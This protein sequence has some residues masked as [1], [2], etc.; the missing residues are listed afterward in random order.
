MKL[1]HRSLVAAISAALALSCGGRA[2]S[3]ISIDPASVELSPNGKQKFSV[4][5]QGATRTAV[6]W[7][8]TDSQGSIDSDGNY[9]AGST[10][11]QFKVVATLKT[12]ASVS[13]SATVT[14]KQA[15]AQVTVTPAMAQVRSGDTLRLTATVTGV[16]DDGLDW[17]VAEAD[18]G[19]VDASG[20]YTAPQTL[21]TYT[22]RATSVERK[23][24][25]GE[26][27]LR[28]VEHVG[29][30]VAPTQVVLR[31]GESAKF[32]AISA[33]PA[34]A[35]VRWELVEPGAP[36]NLAQDGTYTAS[37]KGGTL[38][39][40]AVSKQD[41]T[42]LATA[43]L[44]V[45]FPPIT[46]SGT[47]AVTGTPV[48]GPVHIVDYVSSPVTDVSP[49]VIL[50]APGPFTIE[51][52]E[53]LSSSL[54]FYGFVDKFGGSNIDNIG[55]HYVDIQLDGSKTMGL[56]LNYPDDPPLGKPAQPAVID[57]A[58]SSGTTV[59]LTWD[60]YVDQATG[61]E[62]A[63][64]YR[65]YWSHQANPGPQNKEGMLEVPANELFGFYTAFVA[66]LTASQ[67]YNFAVASVVDGAEIAL[68]TPQAIAVGSRSAGDRTL[69][70]TVKLG[71]LPLQGRL[72]VLARSTSFRFADLGTPT[73]A[74]V[75]YTIDNLEAGKT[76]LVIYLWDR[77]G[78]GVFNFGVDR[79]SSSAELA[80]V[81]TDNLPA[82]VDLSVVQTP[83]GVDLKSFSSIDQG[84][85]NYRV[86]ARFHP[87]TKKLANVLRDPA[88]DLNYAQSTYASLDGNDYWPNF[89]MAVY[90]T[91]TIRVPLE[92]GTRPFKANATFHYKLEFID[93]TTDTQDVTL[94]E[95]PLAIDL[96]EPVSA[97]G[98]KPT[99]KWAAL[100]AGVKATQRLE[101]G[102][103][104]GAHWSYAV[105]D[106]VTSVTYNADQKANQPQLSPGHA[107]TWT[108]FT[109]TS[110]A[111]SQSR[112][113][114]AVNTS[115]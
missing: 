75:P 73:T 63:Q 93:G 4:T 17:S 12:D 5:V 55:N 104:S 59:A 108:L 13:A 71:A 41:P 92:F 67:T 47:V 48:S 82:S 105:P 58:E 111:T 33:D 103:D 35:D 50:S 86:E 110:T 25:F 84:V 44:Y 89:D 70:G 87:G 102:D 61:D 26:A 11:G 106:G 90:P 21:G 34:G 96:L 15:P 30:V 36:G 16:M 72:Y 38:T 109:E 98:P 43:K 10:E 69:R 32:S 94:A 45:Y 74:D 29:L 8:T 60:A 79:R 56:Q 20:L 2:A 76:Y 80:A 113:T 91:G 23:D 22:V 100:P 40:R 64:Q 81:D 88:P 85:P 112:W 31:P 3:S 53:G 27:K 78:D 52:H 7:S 65:I 107:A 62:V 6:A 68:S 28:V 9:V 99:F 114:F 83:L 24:L 19:T 49:G 1:P 77:D 37:A 66:G 97:A 101:V 39:V 46:L 57:T 51:G 14:I 54:E 18:G 42:L 95:A 115:N